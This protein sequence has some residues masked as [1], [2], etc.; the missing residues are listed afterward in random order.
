[1]APLARHGPETALVT[2]ESS[3]R[4]L[5]PLDSGFSAESTKYSSFGMQPPVEEEEEGSEFRSKAKKPLLL[6][7]RSIGV[8]TDTYPAGLSPLPQYM[9]RLSPGE[10]SESSSLTDASQTHSFTTLLERATALLTRMHQADPLTLSNRLKRQHLTGAEVIAHLSRT[11]VGSI[12]SEAAAL[13]SH[14]R[15]V[16]EDE[17]ATLTA[18]RK[19]LRALF[20]L[21]KD[22]FSEMGAMRLTLNEVVLDPSVAVRVREAAMNP[23]QAGERGRP[24]ASAAAGAGGGWMAPISKLFGGSSATPEP[25]Q[26]GPGRRGTGQTLRAPPK[27]VPKQRPAL[28]AS[29]TTV[30]VEFSGA[31]VGRAVTNTWKEDAAKRPAGEMPR[32]DGAPS[33]HSSGS[34]AS[35]MGIFAG[36]PA[37]RQESD[38]WVVLPRNPAARR[39]SGMGGS[40][41]GNGNP[42]PT[43]EGSEAVTLG[44]AAAL[45]AHANAQAHSHKMSRNVDAMLDGS[46]PGAGMDDAPPLLQRT[47][48]RR[49]ASDSSMHSTFSSH[50]VDAMA[51]PASPPR[52]P[53]R[54][55]AIPG[56]PGRQR[57]PPPDSAGY[58]GAFGKRVAS[59]RFGTPAMTPSMPERGERSERSDRADRPADLNGL[60][61]LRDGTSTPTPKST[62]GAATDGI[63][64]FLPILP[65]LTNWA[66]SAA[67]SAEP[68]LDY[69]GGYSRP[70]R[71][72]PEDRIRSGGWM[73][74]NPR[75][76]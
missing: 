24:G 22:A 69:E 45:R 70:V 50:V 48:R 33:M 44:R 3:S 63:A 20:K 28:A 1:M 38:P 64:S 49:G 71:V 15:A 21:L 9:D 8:Q 62:P 17:K 47:L 30:N 6:L 59:F 2:P 51:D 10:R 43:R 14:Y 40:S 37:P 27:I 26:Q 46:G 23:S 73:G 35:V 34:A 66:A 60:N 55:R 4:P 18:G 76:M 5:S 36:A 53:V 57:A 16:L 72:T 11:T 39:A 68:D 7:N 61:G 19:E 52:S 12:I 13:R 41:N 56:P 75:E 58:F 67:L 31:G 74:D 32:S 29:T 65:T 42:P 25:E 54:P